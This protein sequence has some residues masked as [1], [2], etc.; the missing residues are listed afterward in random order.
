MNPSDTSSATPGETHP[1]DLRRL[2]V[3]VSAARSLSFAASAQQLGLTPSAV[4]HAI[5]SLE[6]ELSCILFQRHGPRVTLTRAGIRLLPIARD[7]LSRMENL[8]SEV[9]LIE[10]ESR[11]L[12][13]MVPEI[14]CAT[15]LPR[16]LP[17]FFECFP[18]IR[19]EAQVGESGDFA[20][21][22]LS[23]RRCD[24]FIGW[25]AELPGDIVRRELWVEEFA[26]HIAPFHPLA[27]FPRVDNRELARHTLLIPHAGILEALVCRGLAD[28]AHHGRVWILPSLE[29]AREFARVGVG[30]A[31]L[32]NRS[33]AAA[34]EAGW[35]KPLSVSAPRI[36]LPCSAFWNGQVQPS[37]AAEAFLSLVESAGDP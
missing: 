29:C 25:N 31:V 12:R 21:S 36:E 7:L 8:R 26:I 27:R 30:A 28:P 9:A 16:I 35:L 22:A 32:P 24:L 23:E 1:I 18:S 6:E 10:D 34:V 3:F 11:Q 5:R 20:A 4:S 17:S 13:V 19:F 15:L 14:L 33:A 37:W 2:Q